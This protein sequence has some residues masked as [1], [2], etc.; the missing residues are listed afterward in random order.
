MFGGLAPF[1][2]GN[3]VY[4]STSRRQGRDEALQLGNWDERTPPKSDRFKLLELQ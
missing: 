1:D 4:R 3:G 2:H